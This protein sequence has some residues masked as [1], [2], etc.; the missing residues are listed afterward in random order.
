[1]E[2]IKEGKVEE[3]Y[4]HMWNNWLIFQAGESTTTALQFKKQLGQLRK[5]QD[6]SI[7]MTSLHS[8]NIQELF[9]AILDGIYRRKEQNLY[10]NNYVYFQELEGCLHEFLKLY[11]SKREIIIDSFQSVTSAC[12]SKE[13]SPRIVV[14]CANCESYIFT[15]NY[16]P[17]CQNSFYCDISCQKAH[18]TV[19]TDICHSPLMPNIMYP[20]MIE[21]HS[22]TSSQKEISLY[23]EH[24]MQ[25]TLRMRGLSLFQELFKKEFVS[26]RWIKDN[27]FRCEMNKNC[28]KFQKIEKQ[29]AEQTR[30]T[31]PTVVKSTSISPK[32]PQRLVTSSEFFSIS[33][34]VP[35]PSKKKNK[36][37]EMSGEPDENNEEEE[38]EEDEG[39]AD[40]GKLPIIQEL[41]RIFLGKGAIIH[42]IIVETYQGVTHNIHMFMFPD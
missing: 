18:K 14:Q 25:Y 11:P 3:T 20:L 23:F 21:I 24:E 26:N 39:V 7:R 38:I 12:L 36:R 34:L 4:K 17:K 32:K 40:P 22:T 37:G 28:I 16:C 30:H 5:D 2:M 29:R 31:P 13:I 27:H 35:D 1:M 10:R 42:D 41:K 33:K 15:E 19:H 9:M 6:F 8:P